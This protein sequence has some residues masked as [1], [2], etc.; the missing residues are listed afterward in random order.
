M[1]GHMED[2]TRIRYLGINH[3]RRRGQRS[4]TET[5]APS[6]LRLALQHSRMS[7]TNEP[8]PPTIRI[9]VQSNRQQA[10]DLR[11]PSTPPNSFTSMTMTEVRQTCKAMYITR[12]V[13]R[14]HSRRGYRT[15][16][17]YDK[18]S[19]SNRQRRLSTFP[20]N[21]STLRSGP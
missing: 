3:H 20:S 10:M 11:C 16:K 15:L 8:A 2:M 12:S 7:P 9:Q 21:L 14:R 5:L 17:L 1:V 19:I 13:R 4:V 6:V 18:Y